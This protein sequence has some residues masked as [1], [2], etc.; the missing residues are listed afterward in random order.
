MTMASA[1]FSEDDGRWRPVAIQCRSGPDLRGAWR[2]ADGGAARMAIVLH[3]ATGVPVAYYRSFVE[4]L[5]DALQASVLVY[6][7]RDTGGSLKRPLREV[8]TTMSDWGLFDQSA[9]LALA[10]S[11]YPDLP[12][13]VIGHSLG[14]H[15]LAFHEDI[16]RVDR[17]VA[18]A[19]G[20]AHW[21][22]HPLARMPAVASLWWLL[23]PA[24][25]FALG[26]TPGR[27]LG[28]GADLPAGVFWQWRRWCL[29]EGYS[30]KDW[31]VRLPKPRLDKARFDL[32]LV[33]VADDWM[34]PPHV[35]WRLAEFYPNAR[36][37]RALVDPS[38]LNLPEIGHLA[39]F[40]ERNRAA[41]PL[42][43]AP[44]R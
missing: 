44:L 12:L 17:V 37:S 18:V 29:T 2:D 15:W 30:Q 27:A 3:A 11:T 20:P 5:A 39:I 16:D 42:L 4:W 36:V 35:V 43:A 14:G 26:Y 6:E 1:L 22:T 41:W 34:I 7:Y 8:A 9:A 32:H 24:A 19:S 10:A 28:L 33:G 13:R 38:S 23:G 21:L 40:R 25:T 31:G